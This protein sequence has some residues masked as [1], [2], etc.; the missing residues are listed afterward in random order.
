MKLKNPIYPIFWSKMVR[1]LQ[2]NQKFMNNS[3]A[4][5]ST[6]LQTMIQLG[7]ESIKIVESLLDKIHDNSTKLFLVQFLMG[8]MGASL[9][10]ES[11]Q[12]LSTREMGIKVRSH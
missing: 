11:Y 6:A 7:E 9:S 4:D 2:S 3:F 10:S 12:A 1:F 8:N 5:T